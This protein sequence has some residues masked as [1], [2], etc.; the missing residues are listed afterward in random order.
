[1]ENYE[2]IKGFEEYYLINKKGEVFSLI[3]N[4]LLKQGMSTSG[5]KQVT[6][7]KK[8]ICKRFDIHRLV[9]IQFL[10]NPDN[11]RFVNHKNGIKTDNSIDNLEWCTPSENM[12]H[13]FRT[14]LAPA[15]PTRTGQFGADHNRSK[16]IYEFNIQ[17]ELINTYGSG[18][19]YQRR[20]GHNHSCPHWSIKNKRP[21][22]GNYYS[23]T[24]NFEETN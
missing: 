9:A 18:L 3:T 16:T 6:L 17:G 12:K 15:P 20:T 23:R 8:G 13:A 2:A 21:I 14:G 22:H 4:K 1:M 11:K 10:D 7:C 19:E 5:Y 24:P